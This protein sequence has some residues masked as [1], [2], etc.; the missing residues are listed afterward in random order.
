MQNRFFLSYS[1]AA[2]KSF[3]NPS[4]CDKFHAE[5]KLKTMEVYV[6]FIA[7]LPYTFVPVGWLS[8]NGATIA[9][10]S[11]QV[12]YSL[13]GITFGGDGVTNFKIPDIRSRAIVGASVSGSGIGAGLTP[14]RQGAI[15]GVESVTL[16]P[17]QIPL[18]THSAVI[19][20]AS[21]PVNGTITAKMNVSSNGGNSAAS[22][23]YLAAST[24][25]GD[26]IYNS[27][28]GTLAAL[29]NSSIAVTTSGMNATLNNVPVAVTPGPSGGGGAHENRMPYIAIQYCIATT[30]IYP[31][32]P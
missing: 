32:R 15:G 13:I 20:N 19:S 17:T 1:L 23:N 7:A 10:Q 4:V 5:E 26:N 14:Q 16:G 28:A 27:A 29:N 3:I 9:I 18:H 8:C 11:N 31:Q 30:G 21:A 2:N 22:G 6:G 25:N 24:S 12:L